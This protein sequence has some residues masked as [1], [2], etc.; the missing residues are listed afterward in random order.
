MSIDAAPAR[1]T[2]PRPGLPADGCSP[3]AED[4]TVPRLPID[5]TKAIKANPIHALRGGMM[6]S[7]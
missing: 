7:F 1:K 5:A 3:D 2:L 4:S 6:G